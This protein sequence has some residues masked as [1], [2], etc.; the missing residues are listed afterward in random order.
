MIYVMWEFQ[1]APENRSKFE[2]AYK[3][4][5]IWAQ[6]FQRDAAYVETILVRSDEHAGT[7]LTI[8]VWKNRESYLQFKQRFAADYAKIDKDCEALTDSERLIG[9]FEKIV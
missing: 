1:V 8:D 2:T 3:G 9:I 7:Y 6:L 4:D 5:G